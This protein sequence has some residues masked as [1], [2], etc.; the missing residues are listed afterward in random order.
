MKDLSA[1]IT[2]SRS[3]CAP[4]DAILLCG[5]LYLVGDALELLGIDPFPR[6]RSTQRA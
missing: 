6:E 1:A 4:S 2:A 3:W 5:S